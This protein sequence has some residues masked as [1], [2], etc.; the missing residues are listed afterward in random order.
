MGESVIQS[1]NFVTLDKK[2]YLS[3]LGTLFQENDAFI[4]TDASGIVLRLNPASRRLFRPGQ[5]RILRGKHISELLSRDVISVFKPFIRKSHQSHGK[6]HS[7]ELQ[8]STADGSIIPTEVS[9][10]R[11]SRPDTGEMDYVIR[12]HDLS[13]IYKSRQSMLK[14]VKDKEIMIRELHHRVKNSLQTIYSIFNIQARQIENEELLTILEESQDRIR[15]M[16]FIHE[17][18]YRS[19]SFSAIPMHEYIKEIGEYL[20]QS[21]RQ[22]FGELKIIYSVSKDLALEVQ[23]ASPCGLII[24]EVISN[25]LKHTRQDVF[26]DRILVKMKRGSDGQYRLTISGTRPCNN[27]KHWEDNQNAVGVRLVVLLAEQLKGKLTVF[28]EPA[29]GIEIM[30]PA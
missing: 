13:E 6:I 25:I 18:L 3:S 12:I 17:C 22:N 4:I 28:N 27:M 8:L 15:T 14:A 20:L 11:F 29:G 5:K 1:G 19:N 30:F 24:N 7:A 16:S 10:Y 23:I 21:Y 9:L 2:S 26:G